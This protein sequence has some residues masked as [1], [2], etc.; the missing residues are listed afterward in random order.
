MRALRSALSLWFVRRALIGVSQKKP[1]MIAG[2]VFRALSL[3]ASTVL[4]FS[5]PHRFR[6]RYSI[7][8]WKLGE[9]RLDPSEEFSIPT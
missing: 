6:Q 5:L 7:E 1:A 3:S 4:R 8:T 9:R 2:N